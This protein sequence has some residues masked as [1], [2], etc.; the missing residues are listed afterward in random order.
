MGL[1][2]RKAVL[3]ELGY[4]ITTASSGLDGLKRFAETDFEL[5]ITDYKM[6]RMNGKKLIAE[7]RQTHPGLPIILLSGFADTL[8]LDEKT[9]GAD[10]VI[11]KSANEVTHMVRA[12]R[13]LLRKKKP[14][15]KATASRRTASK[16]PAASQKA[17][18]AAKRKSG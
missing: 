18:A 2:A 6:P 12:V 3:Q 5:I 9:T 4:Q 17:T 14:A 1:A 7:I 16:K 15:K 11:Q 8:G 13:K 10:A